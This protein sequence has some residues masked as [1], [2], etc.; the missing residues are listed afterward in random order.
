[1]NKLDEILDRIVEGGSYLVMWGA[2][3]LAAFLIFVVVTVISGIIFQSVW[4]G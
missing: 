2:F 4:P 3:L 1:M